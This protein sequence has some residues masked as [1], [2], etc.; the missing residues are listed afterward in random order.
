M[1]YALQC[2]QSL[3][4]LDRTVVRGN[5]CWNSVVPMATGQ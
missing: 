1:F 5:V 4:N 3:R 2:S